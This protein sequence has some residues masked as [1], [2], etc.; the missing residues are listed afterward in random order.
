MA[1]PMRARR[2]FLKSITARGV[3]SATFQRALA[4][5]VEPNRPITAEMIQQ[6]EW[7]A[8]LTLTD[9]DRKEILQEMN[10]QQ[11]GFAAMRAVPLH[12]EQFDPE[13]QTV[14]ICHHGVRSFQ[15][16]MFLERQGWEKVF[17]LNG[18]VAAWARDVDPGMRT[19]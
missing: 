15:V 9:D 7:I 18:G 8:G 16:A 3:G 10:Q 5:Q 13:A 1:N 4:A 12:F 17:N 19:Y 2:R 11:R 6:A 14:V